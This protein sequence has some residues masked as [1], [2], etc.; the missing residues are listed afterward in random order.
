MIR[1]IQEQRIVESRND[2][3][4]QEKQ[5]QQH[6]ELDGDCAHPLIA[7]YSNHAVVLA[8]QI[9]TLILRDMKH[10][11]TIAID[12]FTPAWENEWTNN[13]LCRSMIQQYIQPYLEK[14][15]QYLV[16]NHRRVDED[17]DEDITKD[18]ND[19]QNRHNTKL[20]VFHKVVTST[21]RAMIC[22]YVRCLIHNK[23]DPIAL[24]RG[25]N[26]G[27]NN[28][29]YYFQNS[30]RALRRMYD[31]I[32]IMNKYFVQQCRG[33]VTLQRIVVDE[34]STLELLYECLLCCCNEHY[35]SNESYISKTGAADMTALSSTSSSLESFIVV[36]H[37]RCTN[38]NAMITRYLIG[39]LYVL[40]SPPSFSTRLSSTLRF[41]FVHSH[42]KNTNTYHQRITSIQN[43]L[44][45]LQPDL[46]LVTSRMKEVNAQ[47]SSGDGTVNIMT[48]HNHTK[49]KST[50]NQLSSM[51]ENIY[52]ERMTHGILPVLCTAICVPYMDDDDEDYDFDMT[53][54][55]DGIAEL[56]IHP[57]RSI[58]RKLQR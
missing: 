12:F 10:N 3:A 30:Q 15:R 35:T 32:R 52:E 53:K 38:G 13:D 2:H 16:G 29:N 55:Y 18:S 58:T 34:F 43:A 44:Q 9:P 50:C 27:N 7:L 56:F 37:K 8:E 23:A 33:H 28:Q 5:E 21:V 19:H 46:M 51:L 6:T 39:D 45:Q 42:T 24:N 57:I 11:S 20:Y 31:D 49:S 25:N 40:M 36:I 41:R 4:N 14:T 47:H 26:H 1:T 48:N 22:F 54:P 17:E